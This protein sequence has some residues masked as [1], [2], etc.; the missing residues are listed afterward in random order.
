MLKSTHCQ[1]KDLIVLTQM[2]ES[3]TFEWPEDLKGG[4]ELNL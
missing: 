2:A 1:I 3:D 4:K